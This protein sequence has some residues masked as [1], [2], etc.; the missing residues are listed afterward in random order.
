MGTLNDWRSKPRGTAPASDV[1]HLVLSWHPTLNGSVSPCDV[2]KGSG[3]LIWWKCDRFP[4]HVWQATVFS[5]QKGADCPYCAGRE[6]SIHNSIA[7]SAPRLLPQWHASKNLPRTPEQ[8]VAGSATIAS[9]VWWQCDAVADHAWQ[10]PPRQRVGSRGALSRCPECFTRNSR[11]RGTF[12]TLHPELVKQIDPVLNRGVVV[13][14]LAP[15]VSTRLWWRCPKAP[16]HVWVTS[17]NE[18]V[19]T[20]S[21]CP[22]CGDDYASVTNSLAVA[23]SL[24]RELHPILGARV[25]PWTLPPGSNSHVWWACSAAP[26]HIWE[27]TVEHR[28]PSR[29]AQGCPFCTI[30]V[31]VSVTN[32]LAT[33]Q[34]NLARIWDVLRNDQPVHAVRASSNKWAYFACP[35]GPDHRWANKPG[36]LV[37]REAVGGCPFCPPSFRPSVTNSMARVPRLANSLHP[38]LNGALSPREVTSGTADRFWWKCAHGPDHVWASKASDRLWQQQECPMC[39]LPGH[40][41]ASFAVVWELRRIWPD[42][43]AEPEIV[44]A[45]EG[46]SRRGMTVRPDVLIDEIRLVVEYD[47]ERYH[48]ERIEKDRAKDEKLRSRG[49]RVVRL[50]ESGLPP[51]TSWDTWDVEIGQGDARKRPDWVVKRLLERLHALGVTLPTRARDY[52][53][54]SQPADTEAI[55]LAWEKVLR[56]RDQTKSLKNRRRNQTARQ[57]T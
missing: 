10:H 42:A 31:L 49:F 39:S 43:E 29:R 32:S 57:R 23:T 21:D 45:P 36:G 24:V 38:V 37:Q 4:D 9:A 6:V 1:P 16:D 33:Q 30:G 44:V 20:H 52:L 54:S 5:R 53:S 12:A 55:R 56:Q 18:R 25:S 8:V 7:R 40:S 26:D 11:Q 48:A 17:P 46:R 19:R 28:H 41:H 34:P 13:E 27:A 47:G 15:Q 50:R 2:P 51:T 3:S 22:Y 14:K 35:N